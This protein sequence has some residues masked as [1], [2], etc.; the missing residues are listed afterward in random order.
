MQNLK[1]K[2]ESV[3]K[4]FK[5]YASYKNKR[6]YPCN[7]FSGNGNSKQVQMPPLNLLLRKKKHDVH[8][9]KIKDG[10]TLSFFLFQR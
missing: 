5:A 4:N 1:K 10:E 6:L 2:Q 3:K 8:R 9:G 7:F